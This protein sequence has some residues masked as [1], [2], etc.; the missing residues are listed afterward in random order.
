MEHN[1]K[2]TYGNIVLRQILKSDTEQL[3]L[4]RNDKKMTQFLTPI[5]FITVKI[6]MDWY[7]KYLKDTNIIS[8][9]INETESLKKLIGSVSIYDFNGDYAE[10]GKIQIGEASA[11]GKG[12]GRLALLMVSK[13]GFN[14]LNLKKIS[15][16]V[17]SENI[18][19]L[20]NFQKSGFYTVGQHNSVV[21]GI[22]YELEIDKTTIEKNNPEYNDI[23]IIHED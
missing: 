17:H 15:A 14:E 8:F 22:E 13:L 18:P 6:Q 5:P 7:D 12:F 1:Y 4:W 3:R 21:G 11:H 23:R 16:S 2:I 19:S 10:I 20:R 9:S